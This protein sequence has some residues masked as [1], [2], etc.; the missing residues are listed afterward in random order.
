[1]RPLQQRQHQSLRNRRYTLA[2][3][4]TSDAPS[5]WVASLDTP[6]STRATPLGMRVDCTRL[7]AEQCVCAAAP[8]LAF[9]LAALELSDS[10]DD[11]EAR[12]GTP[13]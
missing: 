2:R 4:P 11:D 10:D 8:G 1:M 6:P 12:P 3:T 5:P 13:P 9:S 7:G